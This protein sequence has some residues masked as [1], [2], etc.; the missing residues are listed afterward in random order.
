MARTE[1]C[2]KCHRYDTYA[3]PNSGNT[4][5]GYSRWNMPNTDK[6]HAYH[7]STQ[8][9]SCFNCHETHGSTNRPTMMV[10]G[11]SPGINSYS[12]TATGGSCSPTCHG[13]ETYTLNYAR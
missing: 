6:G 10:T 9:Y 8:R 12:Q 1:L 2:F 3:N 11:R 5:M 4:I 7:V 13:T